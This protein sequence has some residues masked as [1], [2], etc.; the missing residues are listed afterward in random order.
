MAGQDDP[1]DQPRVAFRSALRR[2][3]GSLDTRNYRLYFTGNLVSHVGG[4]MQTMAEAWL[5]LTLTHSGVAVGA[6]FACRFAPVLLFGLWGGTVAD[7]F[8]R[9]RV[10]L[11][12]QSLA[13]F[14]AVVLW[15]IVLTGV[16]H[17]WMVF[18]L[19]IA[20]G[21]VTVID[22]PA[23][24]AFVEEMVGPERVANAVALNSA[25]GN[26]ARITG[27]AIA[28][29][30]IA[31]VGTAWVFFVNAV[32]FF[33]VVGALLAMNS[34]E[35]R[36]PVRHHE[37][38]RVREGLQYA[39]GVTEIRA[40]ILLVA[41]VGTLVYNFP[42][43]LTLLASDT[44]HGGAGLAGFLMALLGVGT[45]FGAL[46]AAHRARPTS[47]TVVGAAAFLGLSL[48]VAASL[49]GQTAVEIALVP[50]GALAVFFG[51]TANAHMQIWSEPYIRGRVMAIYTML[52]LGTTVVG[53]PFVGWVCGHWSPRDGLALAGTVT[54]TAASTILV[55]RR[56][57]LRAAET[58]P[59]ARSAPLLAD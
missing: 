10:L 47:R 58:P 20:L 24:H 14:L 38:P 19:A 11:V 12:T 8:D 39:W 33:A 52:T 29:L 40:T 35:L 51:S 30:L 42:T 22:E 21:F 1:D 9:R 3:F 34:A 37:R 53:G 6:T 16:V 41:V 49:P 23:Q 13:A 7:R 56:S 55:V 43:F 59:V 44:F 27:P 57:R 17:A 31:S 36:R 15:L 18:A 54:F 50:V 4:W 26:S 32:S 25:V 2:T 48:V 28:G 45:V 5:V 46:T